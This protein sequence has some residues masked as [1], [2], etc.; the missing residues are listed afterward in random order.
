MDTP[1]SSADLTLFD[2]AAQRALTH[3]ATNAA[4]VRETVTAPTSK[5][6]LTIAL[7]HCQHLADDITRA[8]HYLDPNGGISPA[9]S[10]DTLTTVRALAALPVQLYAARPATDTPAQ[11]L[12]LLDTF[13]AAREDLARL[14][15]PN[16]DKPA[17]EAP[18]D[19]P[20]L[21]VDAAELRDTIHHMTTRGTVTDTD[22]R[23]DVLTQVAQ[24]PDAVINR[25]LNVAMNRDAGSHLNQ[26]VHEFNLSAIDSLI[27]EHFPDEATRVRQADEENEQRVRATRAAEEEAPAQ[28]GPGMANGAPEQEAPQSVRKVRKPGAYL[29]R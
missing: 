11:L 12:D 10:D 16:D 4:A 17:A 19:G 25:A 27:V 13:D 5:T 1:T 9:R 29:R 8:V 28:E 2:K 6:G 18:D 20:A 14:L 24:L 3:A 21:V 23:P 22:Y 26:A 7:L 15:T